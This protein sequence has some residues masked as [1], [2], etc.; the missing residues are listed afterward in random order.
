MAA[1]K[2]DAL[3]E[4]LEGEMNQI[5]T[6]VDDRIS[7]MEG[8]VVDLRD[9]MKR[10]LEMHNQTAASWAKGPKGKNTN[11]KIR[12]TKVRWR[13]SREK[14]E[15]PIWSLSR[16]RIEEVG[17]GKGMGMEGRSKGVLI[18]SVGR[19]IM[20]IGRR[21]DFEGGHGMEM[22]ADY[23]GL[24]LV[25]SAGFDPRVAPRVYEKL[26]QITGDS[27]LRDYLSTHPSSKRR[28][29]ILSQ[30]EVMNEALALYRETIAG[31]GIAGF[32]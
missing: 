6:T 14:G 5:K 11:S 26:G 13:S 24:L 4:R 28:A 29:Q 17:M 9:M 8:Q 16:G 25:A 18:G 10:M 12:K 15:D 3:E 23:I 20:A 21:G 22:E 7:S 2:V 30:A 32:L 27:A 19:E 31:H 1:K